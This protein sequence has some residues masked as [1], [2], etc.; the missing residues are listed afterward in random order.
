[1]AD[2]D[3]FGGSGWMEQF[4]NMLLQAVQATYQN[5]ALRGY[6]T[7]GY[8]AARPAPTENEALDAIWSNRPDFKEFYDQQWGDDYN[9]RDAVRNWLGMSNEANGQGA[10]DF[11]LAQGWVQP[12]AEGAEG[13]D[14]PTLEREQ[15]ENE[16]LRQQGLDEEA[17]RQFNEQMQ[18]TR[19]Q[20]AEE[21]RRWNSEFGRQVGLDE[22]A[23]AQ[24]NAEFD[25][26]TGLDTEDA[27]R[28]N[29]E[30]LRQQGLD[31][32]AV[33]QWQATFDYQQQQDA[34][35]QSNYEREFLRQ[36]GLD[37]EA[38]RQWEA[39][40]ALSTRELDV[41]EQLGQGELGLD[42]LNLL[43]SLRG[44]GDWMQ[45]WNVQRNAESTQLPAWASALMGNVQN[46]PAFQGATSGAASN[47]ASGGIQLAPTNDT[48]Q[49]NLAGMGGMF[50]QGH[51]V[52]PAQWNA[53]NPSEQAGLGSVIEFQGGYM[54]DWMQNMVRAAP[55]VGGG[56]GGSYF[57]GW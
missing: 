18:L 43:G 45:Y 50:A 17:I 37:D 11:A 1:M 57:Q 51:Q 15:W 23:I 40:H 54:P 29:S 27:R 38:V 41:S 20:S 30:F 33:R 55:K 4:M 31:T 34:L 47:S 16:F 14:V 35:N 32:E 13:T 44:P 26:Q 6:I 42:Y 12:A 53:L 25:R 52:T 10:V 8:E 21:T 22:E 5:D 9:E 28:W 49:Q 3:V 7:E 46:T 39:E 24:W 19:D 48:A 56:A 36:Q 2:G